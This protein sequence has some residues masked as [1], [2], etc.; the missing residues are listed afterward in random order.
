M[1]HALRLMAALA[2][3]AAMIVTA[4]IALTQLANTL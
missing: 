2:I 4:L 3:P 1:R